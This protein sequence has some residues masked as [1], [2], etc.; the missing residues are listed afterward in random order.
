MLRSG[1]PAQAEATSLELRRAVAEYARRELWTWLLPLP[2]VL[3]SAWVL[4]TSTRAWTDTIL[5]VT[6]SGGVTETTPGALLRPRLIMGV[7]AYAALPPLASWLAGLRAPDAVDSSSPWSV[8]AAW[9][10]RAATLMALA[11][12]ATRLWA[13]R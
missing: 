7:L 12:V 13:H 2:A 6:R 11:W 8:R 1:A 10:A 3:A 5:V 4:A 9:A